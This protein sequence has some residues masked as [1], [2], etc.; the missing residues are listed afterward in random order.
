MGVRKG[1]GELFGLI[2]K[3]VLGRTVSGS[4]EGS[5]LLHRRTEHIPNN[6]FSAKMSLDI[7][8]KDGE[9]ANVRM[10]GLGAGAHLKLQIALEDANGQ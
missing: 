4:G 2:H 6:G 3:A 10:L 1:R 7:S 8:L 9:E 5:S